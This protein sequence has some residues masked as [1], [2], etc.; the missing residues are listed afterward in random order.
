[1]ITCA[2]TSPGALEKLTSRSG[3]DPISIAGFVEELKA[4]NQPNK[5]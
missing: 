4:T 2:I 1:M 3:S 5:A